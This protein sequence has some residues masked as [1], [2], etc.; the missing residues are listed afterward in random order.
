[1]GILGKF[2]R[3]SV[4]YFSEEGL[5]KHSRIPE[6]LWRSS[7]LQYGMGENLQYTWQTDKVLRF[8]TCDKFLQIN[9]KKMG[10]GYKYANE[11]Q[12]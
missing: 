9:K 1:M 12:G 4:Y 6:C 3:I 7:F 2:R 11:I 5:L 10:K 8:P